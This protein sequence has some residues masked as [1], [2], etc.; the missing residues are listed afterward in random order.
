[1]GPSLVAQSCHPN[2]SLTNWCKH[3]LTKENISGAI[4]LTLLFLSAQASLSSKTKTSAGAMSTSCRNRAR[5][6]HGARS[7]DEA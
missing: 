7:Q 5:C 1:M 4:A 2:T 6:V 3:P